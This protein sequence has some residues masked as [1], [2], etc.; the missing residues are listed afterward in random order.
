[1]I[2]Q[3]EIQ[4][5]AFRCIPPDRRMLQVDATGSLTKINKKDREFP[6]I[7]NYFMLARDFGKLEKPAFNVTEMISSRHDT[8]S[9]SEMFHHF[10]FN[11]KRLFP[12]EPLVCRVLV[13]DYSWPT[14]HSALYMF[15]D[16]EKIEQY[17]WRIWWLAL[18]AESNEASQVSVDACKIHSMTE[19]DALFAKISK[20][21]SDMS[22]SFAEKQPT[23]AARKSSHLLLASCCS[24]TMHR[25]TRAL[26]KLKIFG[27]ASHF[28]FAVFCFSLLVNCTDLK[29]SVAVFSLICIT[30][31]SHVDDELSV[32][33][34]TKLVR[35]IEQRPA[36]REELEH[37]IYG[38]NLKLSDLLTTRPRT[39]HDNADAQGPTALDEVE[40]PPESQGL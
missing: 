40:K 7:L 26:K 22:K 19:K 6:T 38:A 5:R 10:I 14:I 16:G 18:E 11:F 2:L 35:L 27:E 12:R 15:N 3:M 30:F 37:V 31:K 1:M 8:F 23:A 39:T 24:H 33:A 36:E 28:S 20:I 9:I 17:Y 29:T 21:L 34:R 32:N 4:L 25:F 13:S